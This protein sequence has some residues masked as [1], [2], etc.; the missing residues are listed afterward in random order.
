M[1]D[2]ITKMAEFDPCLGRLYAEAKE[3]AQ[4]YLFAKKRHRGCDG[5]GEVNNLKDEFS[6]VLGKIAEYCKEKGIACDLASFD[7]DT[8]LEDFGKTPVI[9]G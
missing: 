2:S 4:L 3:Y 1:I 7:R 6:A 8:V 5:L 9:G